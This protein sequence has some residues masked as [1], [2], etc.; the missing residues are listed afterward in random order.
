MAEALALEAPTAIRCPVPSA[1]T[2][3]NTPSCEAAAAF[4]ALGVRAD[5]VA[6]FAEILPL[7]WWPIRA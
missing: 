7:G 1:I 2:G 6:L 3:L 4:A 5:V